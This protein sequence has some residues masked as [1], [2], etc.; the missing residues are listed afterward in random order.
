MR[1]VR[2]AGWA[3]QA[4]SNS[5]VSDSERSRTRRTEHHPVCAREVPRR[6]CIMCVRITEA[7]HA[8]CTFARSNLFVTLQEMEACHEQGECALSTQFLEAQKRRHRSMRSN[9]SS[10]HASPSQPFVLQMHTLSRERIEHF[11]SKTNG[12]NNTGT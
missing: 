6:L 2:P 9:R 11:N 1:L 4:V 7:V 8:V 12:K 5:L 3:T 10:P